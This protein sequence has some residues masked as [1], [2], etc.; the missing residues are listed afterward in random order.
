MHDL[1]NGF[2]LQL[3]PKVDIVWAVVP[4]SR[5]DTLPAIIENFKEQTF[6]GKKLAIVENGEGVGTCK[7]HN[8]EPDVLL[9]S[10]AHQAYAKN[11]ALHYIQKHGGGIWTTWDDDDYYGPRYLEEVAH[12]FDSNINILGKTQIFILNGQNK[13]WLASDYEEYAPVTMVYGPTITG[14]SEESCD[15]KN[16]EWG[17][18][19]EWVADMIAAGAKAKTTSR[20]HFMYNRSKPPGEHVFPITDYQILQCMP[21]GV[22]EFEQVNY[23]VINGA[24]FDGKATYIKRQPR[25]VTDS[26][27]YHKLVEK[28]GPSSPPF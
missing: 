14:R 18:D 11:E 4:F 2:Q 22:L 17:E 24:P 12:N 7:I 3:E 20:Y 23:D 15:F 10:N 5:P 9:T 8:F 26:P 19:N 6:P 27:A 21:K 16:S 25:K 13:L 28:F 1:E